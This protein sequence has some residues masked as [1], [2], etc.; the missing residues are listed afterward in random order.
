MLGFAVQQES[1]DQGRLGLPGTGQ[2]RGLRATQD[3]Q[4]RGV[5]GVK[6]QDF[7]TQVRGGRSESL[8]GSKIRTANECLWVLVAGF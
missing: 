4:V 1:P 5:P 3:P 2:V 6:T 7:R 8:A